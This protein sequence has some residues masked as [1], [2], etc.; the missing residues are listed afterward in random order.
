MRTDFNQFQDVRD[1]ISDVIDAVGHDHAFTTSVE[2]IERDHVP[3]FI[4]Y[5]DGGWTGTA[6]F[7]FYSEPSWSVD[8]IQ[9]SLEQ[10]YDDMVEAFVAEHGVNPRNDDDDQYWEHDKWQDFQDQ[11]EQSDDTCWFVY[12]RAIFYG[13]ENSR[14]ESGEDEFF[15]LLGVNTDFNYGRDYVSYAPSARTHW[16]YE[17]AIPVSQLDEATLSAVAAGMLDAWAKA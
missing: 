10:D 8:V 11:W 7:G 15:F 2:D 12:A 3:G 6:T 16:L 13:A 1:M 4:P 5:T 9:P 17:V 14:N